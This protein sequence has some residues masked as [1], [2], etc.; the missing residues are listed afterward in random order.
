[1]FGYTVLA[2]ING[3]Y[4]AFTIEAPQFKEEVQYNNPPLKNLSDYFVPGRLIEGDLTAI[5]LGKIDGD[6][7]SAYLYVYRD[8]WDTKGFSAGF[9]PIENG[10]IHL[11]G[12]E[13]F[14]FHTINT[15]AMWSSLIAGLKLEWMTL[16][17]T[18]PETLTNEAIVEAFNRKVLIDD[19]FKYKPSLLK[20]RT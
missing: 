10:F 3:S 9:V 18:T 7:R 5:V 15:E 4:C 14:A 16:S 13:F 20:R 17:G 8:Q 1:M 19:C 6:N 12:P 11:E 2:T